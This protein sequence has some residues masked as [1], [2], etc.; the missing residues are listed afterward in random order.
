MISTAIIIIITTI[1]IIRGGP[2]TR[3]QATRVCLTR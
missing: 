2:S 1:L 3:E